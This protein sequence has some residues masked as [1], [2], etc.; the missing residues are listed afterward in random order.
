MK[1]T[2]DKNKD[3][4]KVSDTVR[5]LKVWG[6]HDTMP[7]KVMILFGNKIRVQLASKG[8][9]LWPARK[10]ILL[11]KVNGKWQPRSIV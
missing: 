10:C 2:L 7:A 1:K 8:I 6:E 5:G 9:E 4:I 11:K 3:E